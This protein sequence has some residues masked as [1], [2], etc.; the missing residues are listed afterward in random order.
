MFS[1]LDSFIDA[2]LRVEQR[3]GPASRVVYV[4]YRVPNA[5]IHA[6]SEIVGPSARSGKDSIHPV[7]TSNRNKSGKRRELWCSRQSPEQRRG[8]SRKA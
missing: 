3:M 8:E 7:V 5:N 6:D 2:I 1:S 4:Q